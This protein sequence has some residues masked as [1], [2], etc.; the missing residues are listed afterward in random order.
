ME[1]GQPQKRSLKP[2]PTPD[3][4]PTPHRTGHRRRTGQATHAAPDRSPTLHR[5]GHRRRTGQATDAAP[6]R[7]PARGLHGEVFGWIG[8]GSRW[9]SV[10]NATLSVGLSSDF[11]T[12][13][14]KK[15][16]RVSTPG[17]LTRG[18]FWTDRPGNPME[19]R[20][21]CHPFRRPLKRLYNKFF[22]KTSPCK[23]LLAK[24]SK[25][26]SHHASL[27]CT[28]GWVAREAK[29]DCRVWPRGMPVRTA[30]I[31]TRLIAT[32]VSTCCRWVLCKQS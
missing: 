28:P 23:T 12:N 1:P 26:R 3:R 22:Q 32:A 11:T 21:Q 18:G 29:D 15:P 24:E 25:T 14:P 20:S 2:V 16:P 5:T 8:L 17:G 31:R 4:P 19:K 27:R 9:R 10:P 6:G 13:F 7:P 30:S